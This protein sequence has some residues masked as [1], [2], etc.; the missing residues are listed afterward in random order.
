MRAAVLTVSD[1]VVAGTRQDTSGAA[2]VDLL[3][4][5]GFLVVER[6]LTADGVETVAAELERGR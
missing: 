3:S 2:L 1:G 4:A 5:R 6:A